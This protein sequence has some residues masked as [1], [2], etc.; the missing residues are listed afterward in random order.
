MGEIE[1]GV[2]KQ[3]ELAGSFRK[4]EESG[5]RTDVNGGSVIPPSTTVDGGT[6]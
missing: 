2:F 3:E 6:Q 5:W 1:A 4:D